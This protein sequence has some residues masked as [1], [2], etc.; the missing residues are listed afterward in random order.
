MKFVSLVS[1][2]SAVSVNFDKECYAHCKVVGECGKFGSYC[3]GDAEVDGVCQNIYRNGDR[4][5][6]WVE[7]G[8]CPQTDPLTCMDAQK[9][10]PDT[11][12]AKI[13]SGSYCKVNKSVPTGSV[14]HNMGSIEE[15]GAPCDLNTAGCAGVFPCEDALALTL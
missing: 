7:G 4:Y 13:V 15:T 11:A 2:A 3:K 6:F 14:C 9:Y 8:D 5:C 10:N 12:C 1:V